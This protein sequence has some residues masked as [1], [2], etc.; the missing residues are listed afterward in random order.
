MSNGPDSKALRYIQLCVSRKQNSSEEE[1]ARRLKFGSPAAL[2]RTLQQDGF[3]VCPIC[4]T[5]TAGPKH[6]EPPATTRKRTATQGGEAKE[7]PPA[8][9]AR[10]LFRKA[11]QALSNIVDPPPPPTDVNA[12][13]FRQF[14]DSF[15]HL[16]DLEEHL[17]GERFVSSY[18]YRPDPDDVALFRREDFTEKG[19]VEVC[20]AHGEYPSAN[21]FV[22]D[23]ASVQPQGAKQT[24]NEILVKLIGAYVLAGLPL[25]PLLEKLHPEPGEVDREQLE[26]LVYGKSVKNG[27]HTGGMIDKV[28]QIARV[29]RGGTVRKGPPTEELSRRELQAAWE[30]ASLRNQSHSD[31]LIYQLL[32]RRGFSLSD[33]KRLGNMRPQEPNTNLEQ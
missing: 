18:V 7:L 30:I 19:W 25:E 22:T 5:T 15:D 3:P 11:A 17:Q 12:N 32:Q 33:I 29:V 23:Y 10:D 6:C 8:R 27:R 1:I 2:Y 14:L 13:T 21:A 26:A 16:D 28:R 4:G 24:P 20:E 31:D 9:E